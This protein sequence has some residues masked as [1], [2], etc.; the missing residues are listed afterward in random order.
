[1]PGA[2]TWAGGPRLTSGAWPPGQAS[3]FFA[4]L[5]LAAA[6]RTVPL[7]PACLAGVPAVG[8][9]AS[10]SARPSSRVMT[11]WPPN[12]PRSAAIACIVGE[13]A[14]REANRA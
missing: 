13:V 9:A 14:C 1:M 10:R 6:R 3:V 4:A 11:W 5:F 12:S 7:V 8:A 2:L